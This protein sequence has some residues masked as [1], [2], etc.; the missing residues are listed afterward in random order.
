MPR[1]VMVPN[2][3]HEVQQH[4]ADPRP[5]KQ[6][7]HNSTNSDSEFS[8]DLRLAVFARDF[9]QPFSPPITKDSGAGCG[10]R[11]HLS[12]QQKRPRTIS[13]PGPWSVRERSGDPRRSPFALC[14]RI[15][16]FAG[17]FRA[18]NFRSNAGAPSA[19]RLSRACPL[20]G[21]Q[22]RP[23]FLPAV[24]PGLSGGKSLCVHA[25]LRSLTFGPRLSPVRL[26]CSCHPGT[27]T[28][29]LSAARKPA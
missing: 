16:P 2:Q 13:G 25:G 27:L 12:V 5:A 24:Q 9:P 8:P 29:W 26:R 1:Q 21:R 15:S 7:C 23:G 10:V 22:H 11:F 17:M 4:P 6:H 3:A 14:T 28:D 18:G 19:L 20:W